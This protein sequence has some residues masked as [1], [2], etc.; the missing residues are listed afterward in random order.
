MRKSYEIDMCHGPLLSRILL[1]A[2]PLICS[3]VLQLLFNATDI[4]VVGR[5]VSSNAMAAVGSTSSLINLLV[6]FF[7][8]ISVGANVLVAR[9]R[10]ANDFDDAQQTVQTALITAVFGGFVL[11]A[12]GL[13]LAR[14]MLVW[15]ATPA[16]VLDQAVLYMRVYFIGMPATMLYN[17]GA[18]VLRAVG[19]TRR[20]LYFLTLAGVINVAGDLFFVIVLGMGVA[21]VAVATVLSQIV[22]A[23]LIVLCLMRVDGMCNVNLRRLRFYPDKFRRM[24]QIGLPA[25]L[26]SVIFNISNVLIQSSVNSFGATV[27][28]GNT[29]A[30]NIEGFVYTSMNALYQ[31]SLSFTSQNLGAKQYHRID[32]ILARCLAL[33]LLIGLVLGNG[34]HLFGRTLLGIYSGEADVIEYGMMRLGVVSVTY[35]LCG[36]MDVVAGSVRGLGYSILPMLVSLAGA[37]VFRVIWIFTVFQWQHTLFSLYVSYPISWALTISAHLVCYFVVRRRVFPSAPQ[38][39]ETP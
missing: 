1:F 17:F 24:M 26:Q 4:I 9:F 21:G 36:M 37:C 6:N 18:A 27:V 30:S 32:Q 29:A 14:P 35:C 8:G 12:A 38:Q 15:M 19:D 34:A 25:G 28:A 39:T 10:G 3:G 11:I 2:V 33:V 31:T 22:S 16:E 20:P 7:I 13:L 5:F 23:T